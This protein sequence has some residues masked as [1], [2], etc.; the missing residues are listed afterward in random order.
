MYNTFNNHPFNRTTVQ[1]QCRGFLHLPLQKCRSGATE[2]FL[3]IV[4]PKVDE[5][6]QVRNT[7]L[8]RWTFCCALSAQNYRRIVEQL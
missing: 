8:D 6:D 5:E 1:E 4:L 7:V 3:R 2:E